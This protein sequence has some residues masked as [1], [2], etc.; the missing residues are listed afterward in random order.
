[1]SPEAGLNQAVRDSGKKLLNATDDNARQLALD[2][3]TSVT[4][5]SHARDEAVIKIGIAEHKGLDMLGVLR[6]SADDLD[7]DFDQLMLLATEQPKC[8]GDSWIT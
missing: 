2:E 5:L 8:C 7:V 6:A 1:M 3:L 4:K